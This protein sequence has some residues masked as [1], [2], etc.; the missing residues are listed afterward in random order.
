VLAL[1]YLI[2]MVVLGDSLCRRFCP[3]VSRLH[4]IAAAFLVGL[5]LSTWIT[6]LG[7][8]LFAR[9]TTPL[10]WGNVLFFL[11][12]GGLIF[13]LRRHPSESTRPISALPVAAEKWDWILAG[14]YLIFAGWLMFSTLGSQAGRLRVGGSQWSDFGPNLAIMQSFALG[15]NF[16]TE[17]PHYAG[18]RIRYHFLFYFQAGNLEFLGLNPAWSNNLL[19]IL[20]LVALLILVMVLGETLFKSR[21]VGR[22]GSAL[23]LFNSSLAYIP[24][25]R[26]QESLTG[27]FRSV[28]KLPSFLA[29]GFPYRGEEWGFW[30][31]I[32]YANQRHLA[33]AIGTLLL[34]LIF[35][36]GRYR[37]K[38][39]KGHSG[40][41]LPADIRTNDEEETANFSPALEPRSPATS[42][43]TMKSF[44]F[45]GILLGALPLWNSAVF[46]AAFAMLVILFLVFPL[47]R[48]MLGLALA[49]AVVAIPQIL[50]LKTGNLQE[51]SYSLYHWGYIV[52]SPTFTK[53]ISYLGFT[54]G[55]K[56][57]LVILALALVSW[58]HWRV[59]IATMSLLAIAFFFQMSVE[60]VAN[61]KFIH[62]WVIII[63]LFAAYGLWRLSRIPVFGT[64]AIGKAAAVV[65]A[66]AITLGGIID[67]FPIHNAYWIET[68]FQDDPIVKWVRAET[69]PKA[70]FLTDQYVQHPILLAGRRIFFGWPYFTWGLGYRTGEREEIYRRLFEERQP[71]ELVRLL[72]ENGIDYVVVDDGLRQGRLVKNPNESVYQAFFKKVFEDPSTVIFKV[73]DRGQE[74][75]PVDGAPAGA[76][77]AAAL[78]VNMFAG[79]SGKGPG[80]FSTPKGIAVDGAGNVLVSDANNGRIQKFSPKGDYVAVIGRVGPGEGELR[81]PNGIAFDPAGNMYVVDAANQRIQKFDPNGSFLAQWRGPS[82]GFYW[83]RDIATG[84]DNNVYVVD[85]GRDRIVVFT[86]NGEFVAEWGKKGTGDSEFNEP[87]AAAVGDQKVYVADPRNGRIQV[88]DTKGNFL[89]KWS[90]DEWQQNFSQYPDLVLDQKAGRLYASSPAANEVLVFDLTGQRLGTA[91]PTSPDKLEGPTALALTK[92]K[93]LFVLNSNAA[94]VSMIA[95]PKK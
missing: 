28:F 34:V 17:Y 45:F 50:Y 74:L 72:Q 38:R 61:H 58:F 5:V 21:A 33:S 77:A 49:T 1:L 69:D 48:Y 83:P 8:L 6:Y 82:P 86:S 9:T 53:V 70:V 15:H 84:P 39:L 64:T 54:F 44:I 66:V 20:S 3:Y 89:G 95:L 90:V 23:L 76:D 75:K 27:A 47:K 14:V 88:F 51:A 92:N 26:S 81:D 65:L 37:E 93:H 16:P 19:S 80:Q 25:L 52:E 11:I 46:G 12:A 36:I 79:G 67:L 68:P 30:T 63:N 85:Q 18:E 42:A 32:T 31:M 91:S 24:F 13:W 35:L 41:A 71:Q 7:A 94:R 55:L 57:L 60:V 2:V 73:P 4:R 40:P 10:L 62:I 43:V 78:A 29:S 22:I 56:W 87:T 59:F